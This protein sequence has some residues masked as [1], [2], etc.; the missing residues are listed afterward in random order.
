MHELKPLFDQKLQESGV[1]AA[2]LVT[3]S[4]DDIRFLCA[5]DTQSTSTPVTKNTYF[6]IG[7][8]TKVFTALLASK[9]ICD[10]RCT[11]DTPL[12]DIL[13]STALSAAVSTITIRE[14]LTHTSGLPRLPDNF[15][16]H[17]SDPSDPYKYYGQDQLLDYLHAATRTKNPGLSYSNLGYGLLGRLMAQIYGEPFDLLLKESTTA[18]F[19]MQQT[20]VYKDEDTKH[21]SFARGHNNDGQPTPYWNMNVLSSAGSLVSTPADM[22]LFLQHILESTRHPEWEQASLQPLNNQ[23]AWGWFRKPGFHNGRLTRRLWHNGMT[24][25][26]ASHVELEIDTCRAFWLMMNKSIP[27]APIADTLAKAI[28]NSGESHTITAK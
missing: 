14:L 25:G 6:Q 18:S 27:P 19:G 16:K 9:A 24:G 22:A 4:K 7:S 20:F 13:P 5:G 1:T 15:E 17:M 26:F 23:M 21:P 28:F 11:L 10:N 8:V 2:A 12:S 3:V